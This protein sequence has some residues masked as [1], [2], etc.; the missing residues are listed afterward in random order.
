MKGMGIPDSIVEEVRNRG[1]LVE[2]V[3][4]ITT[5]KRSGRTFRGPCPLH[6]GEETFRLCSEY[7]DEMIRVSTDEICA[8]I[9]DIF[10][11]E[12]WLALAICGTMITFSSVS[13]G[14]SSGIGSGSVT[15]RPAPKIRCS[16]RAS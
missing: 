14:L 3:S 12:A 7:V 13:S 10:S 9:Q 15:S 2:I 8:A 11:R 6:G 16:F 5:L 4:E 1:D